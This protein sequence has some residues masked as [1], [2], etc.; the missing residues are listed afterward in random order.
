MPRRIAAVAAKRIS[1]DEGARLVQSG[2]WLDY[3][4]A[5]CGPDVF[6]KALAVRAGELRAVKIR[7]CL[8]LRP[9]AVVIS[10]PSATL[11]C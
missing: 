7:S 6:D 8:S 4:A 2:M 5:L 10:K 9:R 11:D 1:A 3:G